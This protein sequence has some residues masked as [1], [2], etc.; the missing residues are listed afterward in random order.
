MTINYEHNKNKQLHRSDDVWH[1]TL[2]AK[3]HNIRCYTKMKFYK[4]TDYLFS[5]A[6]V[7]HG[8]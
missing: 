4:V 5:H 3:K 8:Q 2:N 6:L 7:K 1:N